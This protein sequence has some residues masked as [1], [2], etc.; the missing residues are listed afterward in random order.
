VLSFDL[1][2]A[3]SE[4]ARIMELVMSGLTYD[5]CL[6]YLDDILIFSKTFDEHLDRLATVFDRLDCYALNALKLKLSKCSLFQRKVSFLG[7]VVSG[8]GI[9]CDPDK[10]A[11]IATW[12]T[13]SNIAEVRTFSGLVSYYRTFVCNFAAIARPL[14]N[15]TKKGAVFERT[16]ECKTAFQELKRALT[17]APIL[18]APCDDG[19]YVLDTDVSD[20]ALGAVLQQEQNGKL[21]VIGY[22]SRTLTPAEARYCIT[23]RELLRVVF[24]LKKYRQHLLGR[25]IIVRMDHAAL[26]YLMKMPEPVG[27]QGRWL[28]LLGEYNITIQHRPGRVHGNSDALSRRPCERSSEV[29]C[30]QCPRATSTPA[31]VPTSRE[32]L[33]ADSSNALPVLLRFP[34]RHTQT[35]R[36]P[37]LILSTGHADS[38]SD[39]LEVPVFPV[40]PSDATHASPTNDVKAWTQVFG[41][42][43][44]PASLSLEDIRNAQ[45]ADDSLQ[46]VIQALGDG[47]KLPRDGLRDHPEEARILFAQWDSLVLE[48]SILYRRYHYPDGTT[49]Y[50]QVVLPAKLRR[51]YIECLHADLGHF[52]RTKTCLALVR[53]AYFP[54]W[55]LLTGMLVRNCTTCNMHHRSHQKPRQANLKPMRELR[56]MAVIHADLVGP[57]PEGKN[58]RN[59]TGFQYILS[60]ID[61]ATRYL[62]LLPIRHKTAECVAATLFDEVISRVSVPSAILTDQGGEFTGEVVECLLQWLG[63]SH[64]KTSAYHPQTDAKCERVHYSVH[65]MITKMIND[66]HERWPDL[67]GAVALAYN[68]TV[69]TATGYSPHKLFCS[70]APSCPLDAIVSTPASD[71]ASNADEFALQTFERLQEAAAFVCE[72]TGKNMQ[73]MKRHY[74]SI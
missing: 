21:H 10:V 11:S 12:P 7:H 59:Q 70:F 64:L 71:P 38:A 63:I 8:H 36:S 32:A 56:P 17:S 67:L 24:G 6:V 58:S 29:D 43:A 31:V 2:N 14:H 26:S 5:V 49:Q 52:G 51:P 53:R 69:H 54:G 72:F 9:E 73:Q 4:F 61:S 47:V 66:K 22:T 25:S 33:L 3:P 46:P 23:H 62:W 55:R 1:A 57:L 50:L 48:D 44:E 15:L 37:D 74:D 35:G 28:D 41:V 30:W 18:V 19:T 68:A 60:V 13:L 39:F 20:T 42:T 65:N 27:Q 40:L 45:A 16:P 34:P